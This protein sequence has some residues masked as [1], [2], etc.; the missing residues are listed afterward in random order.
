M[1]KLAL[2]DDHKL[3]RSG[4][5]ALLEAMEEFEIG[6]ES[7]NGIQLIQNMENSPAE[8]VLMDLEMPEMDGMET[9]KALKENIPMP[10]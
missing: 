6:S 9:T 1:I 4:I 3:F 5:R 8:I 2:V 10:K 7:D